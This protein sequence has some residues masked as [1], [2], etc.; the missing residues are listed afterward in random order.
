M[1]S[2][3][4][5]TSLLLQGMFVVELN[6]SWFFRIY[7]NLRKKKSHMWHYNTKQPFADHL[8]IHSQ[9][10]NVSWNLLQVLL[11]TYHWTGL[12]ILDY[13]YLVGNLTYS[14]IAETKALEPLESWHFCISNSRAC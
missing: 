10:L 5:K 4:F 13:L 11:I 8:H 12:L 9:S 2:K 7:F 1:R 6:R 3:P 14:K